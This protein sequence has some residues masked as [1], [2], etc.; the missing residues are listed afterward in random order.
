MQVSAGV[1]CENDELDQYY[2]WHGAGVR[3]VLTTFGMVL[4]CVG[5]YLGHGA[6]VRGVLTTFGTVLACVGYYLWHGPSLSSRCQS[7]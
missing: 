7:H 5:Y 3:G 4:A 2:L 6:G 1:L